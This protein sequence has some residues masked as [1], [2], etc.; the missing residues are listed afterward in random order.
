ME[1]AI[2]AAVLLLGQAIFTPLVVVLGTLFITAVTMSTYFFCMRTVQDENPNRFVR[3]VM[4]ATMIKFFLFIAGAGV[5]LLTYKKS[6]H[7][8]DL[9]VLMGIYLLFSMTEAVFLSNAARRKSK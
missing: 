4:A 9:Y 1:I 5:L 3:S 7:K 2:I 6:L 8:P